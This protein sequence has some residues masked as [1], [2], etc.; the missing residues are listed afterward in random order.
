M[1]VGRIV[2]LWVE[3]KVYF[4]GMVLNSCLLLIDKICKQFSLFVLI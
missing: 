3:K 4:K 2:W 1:E